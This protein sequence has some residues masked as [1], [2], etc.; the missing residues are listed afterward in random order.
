M[1]SLFRFAIRM[2]K[3]MDI[4]IGEAFQTIL[5]EKE[6][7][8]Q[9]SAPA[10]RRDAASTERHGRRQEKE[11]REEAR[12]RCPGAEG[13]GDQLQP[14]PRRSGSAAPP[15]HHSCLSTLP[16]T[17]QP[18]LSSAPLRM[19]AAR[20]SAEVHSLHPYRRQPGKRRPVNSHGEPGVLE[21]TPDCAI[22]SN[23]NR[24][25]ASLTVPRPSQRANATLQ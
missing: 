23:S 2:P 14:R 6:S 25:S 9:S 13:R 12:R 4:L 24:L 7:Y 11:Q 15:L 1:L 5:W 20:R 8:T 22:F 18:R 21:P 16:G 17:G 3:G 10:A 19:K